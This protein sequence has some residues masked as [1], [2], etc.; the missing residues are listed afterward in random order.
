VR[1]A[2]LVAVGFASMAGRLAGQGRDS[3]AV[4]TSELSAR[5]R[6]I[7]SDAFEGRYPGTRGETLTTSYLISE[8]RSFGLK[9]A[10]SAGSADS[11]RSWLQPVP[12]VVHRP[13]STSPNTARLSGRVTRELVHGRDVRFANYSARPD[14]QVGGELVFA[15]YGISAP[16]YHWD[17]F[18]GVDLH[19]KIVIAFAD[20]P[21]PT[22]TAIFNG[23]RASR[24][25]WA[26]EKI[27]EMER[28]GA[29]AVLRVR[30]AG[31][32]SSARV[33]GVRRPS[34]E[35]DNATLLLS[36]AITDSAL[37]SL[38]PPGMS[39]AELTARAAR[40]GFR[41]VPLGVRLDAQFRTRPVTVLSHNVVATV[42][43]RDPRLAGQ[44]VVLSAH[45]DAY[46]I[47]SPVKGDS[48]YNGAL[49]DGSGVTAL[50]AL[51][52]VFGRHPQRRSITFLFT[53]AEEW[54]L[55]GARAFV[56][57]GPLARDSIVANLN[58]DDGLEFF[59]PKRDAAPLG[60]ELSTLGRTVAQVARKSGLRVSPDPFP[61]EGFFLRADNFPFAVAGIPS[62]Y[63][64]LGADAVGAD[65]TA[66]KTRA[67]EY[68]NSQYHQPSDEYDRVVMDMAGSKQFAEF[69][70]DV[71]IAVANTDARPEWLTGVEFQRAANAGSR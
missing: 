35:A 11:A 49:D 1:R 20:E 45:W 33:T 6:L 58:L 42:A 46:G 48:I 25:S 65:T 23:V 32:L 70:R 24:Y 38:L 62:L 64:A 55:I 14:V 41:A 59:G 44:H 27:S 15:G 34:A 17:D 4:T 10:A 71:A 63:M 56:A 68:L 54:G 50:L 2:L 52:R 22:D 31:S 12:I 43:G 16:V 39:L 40:P 36:G 8:L 37:A 9:P 19:G 67:H 21:P 28:R 60:V 26:T 53:T 3:L 51:A 47:D 18:A 7:S 57:D 13:D 66:V 30:P 5:L 69:V 61:T 29:V